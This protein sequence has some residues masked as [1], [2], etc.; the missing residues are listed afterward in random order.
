MLC[1]SLLKTNSS[2]SNLLPGF[3][4]SPSHLLAKCLCIPSSKLSDI[5]APPQILAQILSLG[6][7]HPSFVALPSIPWSSWRLCCFTHSV[8]RLFLPCLQT[9]PRSLMQ[10]ERDEE[11]KPFQD[12]VMILERGQSSAPHLRSPVFTL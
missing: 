6:R 1:I 12:C 4:L 11:Q 5:S 8:L 9:V 3:S 2:K 10:S 7:W